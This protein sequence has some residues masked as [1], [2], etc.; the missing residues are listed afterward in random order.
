M[1]KKEN[2]KFS[3]DLSQGLHSNQAFCLV[4]QGRLHRHGGLIRECD[5]TIRVCKG[6]YR[7]PYCQTSLAACSPDG[8]RSLPLWH[9]GLEQ[10]LQLVGTHGI[11]DEDRPKCCPRG[12]TSGRI[13]HRHSHYWRTV[14]TLFRREKICIF[15]FRCP[16][17]GYVHS[18][19]PAFLEPYQ[20][21][22]LDLQ[23]NIV[24][25]VQQGATLEAV[26]EMTESLPGGGFNERTIGRLN[27]GWNER[28]LQLQI[29]LW[30]WLLRRAP[31]LTLSRSTSL[32]GMLRAGWQAVRTQIPGLREVRFLH[33]LNRICFS[34]AVTAHDSNTT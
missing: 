25:A 15:R 6:R 28:L 10:Y 20:Q 22:A 32:W 30:A 21:I 34:L 26:A 13:P 11:P 17:C 19:I 4:G 3:I 23:E 33:G 31:H 24:D 14:F 1:K 2:V 12:C 8:Q 18:V 7:C 29:G 27:R 9:Q 5:H 16:D